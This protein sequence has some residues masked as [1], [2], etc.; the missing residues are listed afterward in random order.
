MPA[1]SAQQPAFGAHLWGADVSREE[2]HL[3]FCVTYKEIKPY[4]LQ[5]KKNIP[6][7]E[8]ICS[9]PFLRRPN[10]VVGMQV[11]SL[12]LVEKL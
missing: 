1:A 3:R 12:K 11:L 2:G 4:P 7:D 5:K 10:S 8:K 9:L 6:L